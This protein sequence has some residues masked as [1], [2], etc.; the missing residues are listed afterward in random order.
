MGKVQ[1]IGEFKDE[2]TFNLTVT[3]PDN[4]RLQ[5]IAETYRQ[6]VLEK[7]G[8]VFQWNAIYALFSMPEA[9]ALPVWK[10]FVAEYPDSKVIGE[11]ARLSTPATAELLADIATNPK[12]R[13][14]THLVA[15]SRLRGMYYFRKQIANPALDA[16]LT[17]FLLRI[18]GELPSEA[19]QPAQTNDGP[20]HR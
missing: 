1:P 8:V 15:K 3:K 9:V 10:S 13:N 2:Q 12:W 6:R 11:L 18:D 17:K 16:T 14:E 5:Q 20:L 19:P 4:A 7:K